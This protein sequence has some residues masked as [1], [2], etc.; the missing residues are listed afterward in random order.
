MEV[1][2]ERGGRIALPPDVLKALG[3]RE[4]DI[5]KL[6]VVGRS[7]V[8]RAVKAIRVDDLWGLAGAHEVNIGDVED[9]LGRAL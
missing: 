3:I 5:L 1:K 9:A 6:E 2:V 8:L 7:I 4:G